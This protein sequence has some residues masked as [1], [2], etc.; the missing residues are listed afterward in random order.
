MFKALLITGFALTFLILGALTT[1]YSYWPLMAIVF[2]GVFLLAL[3]S[4]E[5]ALLGLIIYLPFQV[6]LNIAPG[7]DLASIRVLILLLFSAWILFLLAR[8][9]GKIAT[10]FACHYFVLVTF[11]FWSAVSL[12]WALNL[13]WGLRKIAVFASIFPLYFLVQSATAEKEQV[14]KIISFLVAGASV[15]SVIALIQFFSQF[16]VGLDSSAQFWARNVAPLFYGR[17]LTDAVMANSSWFVNVGGRTYF[18]AVS[19]FPDPHML[20]FY[21]EMVLPLALTMFFV[22]FRP[23]RLVSVFLMLFALFLTFSRGGYLGFA[24]SAALMLVAAYFFIARNEAIKPFLKDRLKPGLFVFLSLFIAIAVFYFSPAGARFKASF[25]LSEGSNV[26]RLQTW[27]QAIAV[28]KS[29]PFAGVGLGSYGLAVNPEAGYRDPTYAHN[30]YLDVWAEL[31]VM[32]LAVWLILLGEFFA[33]P[34]KR[35]I[36]IKT[37]KEKPQ[38]E[39]ILFLLGLIGSLAA[40]SVH[41]LFETAI[42]S[43]VILSLLMIIFAL[44]ANMAKNQEARIMN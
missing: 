5:K 17:S 11:L 31:G 15:V 32:G 8:K 34:F 38:K 37:G 21:L 6:A 10:I 2:F 27:R 28:I 39:E 24:A 3:V 4:P 33:T 1:Y 18:R 20:A 43:P 36:A 42:F 29:A 13:E 35:L 23:W 25:S 22:D 16:F 30:A 9:G 19:F 26:Q 7:I 40:F 14:K 12:F 44:A 41:S